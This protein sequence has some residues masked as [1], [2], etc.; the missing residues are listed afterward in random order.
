M[1]K[2]VLEQLNEVFANT[3]GEEYLKAIPDDA[4]AFKSLG[5]IVRSADTLDPLDSLDRYE[6]VMACEEKFGVSLPDAEIVDI[7]T[8]QQLAD[9]I[10]KKLAA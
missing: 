6:L 4:P 1:T 5:E 8:R 3:F 10:A 9:L 2:P 7:T